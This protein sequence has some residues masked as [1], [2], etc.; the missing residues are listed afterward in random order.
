MRGALQLIISLLLL[1]CG[2]LLR[3]NGGTIRTAR[4][5]PEVNCNFEP[6]EAYSSFNI[7]E[8][9]TKDSRGRPLKDGKVKIFYFSPQKINKT[10]ELHPHNKIYTLK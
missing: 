5:P 9:V 7:E 3:V 1:L 10:N 4:S 8:L 2:R 6:S